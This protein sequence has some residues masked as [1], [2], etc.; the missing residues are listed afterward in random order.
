[1]LDG[2]YYQGSFVKDRM[3]GK[4]CMFL[5]DGR[6]FTGFFK[7]GKPEGPGQMLQD[8]SRTLEHEAAAHEDLLSSINHSLFVVGSAAQRYK[9]SIP[10][11]K[12]GNGG[13]KAGAS[14]Y[15]EMKKG[16]VVASMG[17]N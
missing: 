17:D 13:T 15:G 3:E 14:K 12:Q 9:F 11:N 8:A 2:L 10:T 4:G 5:R 7:A 16:A 6:V 1:M